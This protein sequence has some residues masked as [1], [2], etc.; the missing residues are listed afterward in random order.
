MS[1]RPK[2]LRLDGTSLAVEDLAPVY[3]G[4]SV[5]LDLQVQAP[6]APGIYELMLDP[7]FE[8]VDWFSARNPANATQFEVAVSTSAPPLPA[9]D[10]EP[11]TGG[12]ES[13]D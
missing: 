11:S 7:V 2:T 5:E 3:A 4:D 12:D 13:G 10:R 6:E 9:A 8:Q 1:D